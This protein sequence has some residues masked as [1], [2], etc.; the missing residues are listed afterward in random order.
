MAMAGAM[1]SALTERGVLRIGG[2]EAR[3]FLQGL[4][5]NNVDRADGTRLVYSALLTPQGK[6]L[7]DFFMAADPADK[8]AILL[9]CDGA[10]T[11]ELAKRL[12]MYKLRAKVEIE[13][14]SEAM[15]VAVFWHEDGSPMAEGPGLPDPRLAAMG[16]R[17][18][19][20]KSEIDGA[21]AASATSADEDAWDR[22][23]ISLGIGDAAKDFEPDRTFPLEVNLA[24]LNGIDFQ[25]GCFVGQEVTSRTKRRG[26]VR[27]RLLPVDVEGDMPA[28][29]TPIKGG[30]REVG[31]ILST[32]A[33]AGRALALVRLDLIRDSILEAGLSEIRPEIP[34]W[35]D[36]GTGEGK[37]NGAGENE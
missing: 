34:G 11:A 33:E 5:T 9:D 14:R 17:A 2:A 30:A 36:I 22:H 6:F 32:D 4:V 10:R 16:R 27:K 37:E 12:A 21:I 26:S 29:G 18:I 19:M 35:L 25:K 23:R 28:H 24:E 3:S 7:F 15:G 13:D 1:A 31:T 20:A 8:D